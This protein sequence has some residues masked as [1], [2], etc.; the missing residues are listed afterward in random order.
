MHLALIYFH[1]DILVG[2]ALVV[3]MLPQFNL[4]GH[5]IFRHFQEETL[6][7]HVAYRSNV[8]K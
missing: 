8:L 1:V 3:E 2:Q 5:H 6:Q 4:Q 7:S